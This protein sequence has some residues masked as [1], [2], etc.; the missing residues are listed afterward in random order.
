MRLPVAVAVLA[1]AAV[2]AGCSH[3]DVNLPPPSS[4]SSTESPTTTV[5]DYTG[6]SL[7]PVRGTTSTTAER[8]GHARLVGV[9]NG[10]DGAVPGAIVRAEH[11]VGD[12]VYRHDV[13]VGPD[14]RWD[15]ANVPGGRY[16]VRAF[17][18]PTYAQVEPQVLFV[19]DGEQKTL[20]LRVDRFGNDA[21]RVQAVMAPDPVV[22]GN[23]A[24][25]VV[26]VSGQTVDGAGK[27]R[28]QP[29][30][31]L[32]VSLYGSSQWAA[33]STTTYVTG[34]NGEAY[35][36]LACRFSGTERITASIGTDPTPVSLPASTC[37]EP[38]P[39]TTSTTAPTTS[40]TRPT[41]SRP[42]TTTTAKGNKSTSTTSR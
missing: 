38:A 42:T 5:A 30:A 15:L 31:G 21:P 17:L 39:S 2:L 1:A 33:R 26:R 34:A 13:T 16:R 23:P 11:L 9:V 10:P 36:Q 35:F 28:T 20:S 12:A 7:A 41:T 29:V 8:P 18:A 32:V 14:G 6:V 19:K 22:V 37:V 3:D 24:N 27:V 40:T 25:L 4:T